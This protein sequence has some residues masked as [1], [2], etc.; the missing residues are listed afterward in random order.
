VGIGR[1]IRDPN[2][3]EFIDNFDGDIFGVAIY[4]AAL[5][6]DEIAA[7]SS[8]YQDAG[9]PA[10]ALTLTDGA[11]QSATV[12][13]DGDPADLTRPRWNLWSIDL[14]LFGVDLTDVADL[15]IDLGDDAG[16]AS[17][18]IVVDDIRSDAAVS[19]PP[20]EAYLEAEDADVLGASWR[21]FSDSTASGGLAIGSENGDGD[22]NN[23]APG[24]E[25]VAVYNFEVP[26]DGD[27][28]VVP[29]AQ[30]AGSDSFWVRI[31][32]ATA[33]TLEDPD[34]PGT[35]W[36]RFNGINAPD[37]WALDEVHSND[38]SDE[39]VIWTLP[40]GANTLEIAKREDGTYVDVI[41]IK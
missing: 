3:A 32:T 15:S 16:S 7:H 25:W 23:T 27:Y 31:T 29:R 17:A 1:V 33:Q 37:G 14:A 38:H 11:G 9:L 36:V 30:E 13:Y 41:I 19:V 22:D 12:V 26:A 10:L 18:S 6:A 40:A 2:G 4:D 34:Q 8:A 24:P 28:K 20:F 21:V 35:G 39:V 5:T